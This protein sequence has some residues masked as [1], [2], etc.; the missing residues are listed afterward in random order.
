MKNTLQIF[1]IGS[2]EDLNNL[3]NHY[4]ETDSF[5]LE[6][7]LTSVMRQWLEE[8]SHSFDKTDVIIENNNNLLSETYL[9]VNEG[10]K[11]IC[12]IKHYNHLCHYQQLV[13]PHD[14]KPISFINLF[15]NNY[16]DFSCSKIDLA[17][18]LISIVKNHYIFTGYTDSDQGELF[19]ESIK[20]KFNIEI[21][22]IKK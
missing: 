20:N 21:T 1:K 19:F 8:V 13:K 6:K 10:T 11:L 16:I 2:A 15:L 3:S 14:I 17:Q 12:K 22:Y 4:L 7:S 9:F 5:V 18:L